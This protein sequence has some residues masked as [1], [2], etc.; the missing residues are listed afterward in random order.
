M[1]FVNNFF[2]FLYLNKFTARKVISPTYNRYGFFIE[3]KNRKITKIKNFSNDKNFK[4][5]RPFPNYN[6]KTFPYVLLKDSKCLNV[7]NVRTLQQ[8]VILRNSPYN[9]DVLRT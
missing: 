5:L 3:R 2:Y 4:S 9:W 1:F 7:I 6:F 8:R